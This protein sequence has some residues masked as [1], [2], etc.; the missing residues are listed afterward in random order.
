MTTVVEMVRKALEARLLA[1][2]P[3]L[4]AS[5]LDL[6]GERVPPIGPGPAWRAGE[7]LPLGGARVCAALACS[8]RAWRS[9]AAAAAP[10]VRTL[11]LARLPAGV[12]APRRWARPAGRGRG[13]NEGRGAPT[14]RE[15]AALLRR[16]GGVASLR[17]G[18]G[19]YRALTDGAVASIASSLPALRELRC[20]GG[21]FTESAAHA[22]TKRRGLGSKTARAL[23]KLCPRL[24][25]VELPSSYDLPTEGLVS[26]IVG[27]KALRVLDVGACWGYPH[28]GDL[29]PLEF[30]DLDELLLPPPGAAAEAR[31]ISEL[32][33]AERDLTPRGVCSV[34]KWAAPNLSVLDLSCS[35]LGETGAAAVGRLNG[36]EKLSLTRTT[37]AELRL[38]FAE[39]KPSLIHLTMSNTGTWFKAG[40]GMA[41]MHDEPTLV[42]I[43]CLTRANAPALLVLDMPWSDGISDEGLATMLGELGRGAG[44]SLDCIDLEGASQA[45]VETAE[46]LL[47]GACDGLVDLNLSRCVAMDEVLGARIA[48]RLHKNGLDR[49]MLGARIIQIGRGVLPFFFCNLDAKGDPKLAGVEDEIVGKVFDEEHLS[50]AFYDELKACPYRFY[51]L[52]SD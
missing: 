8:G 50:D 15:T 10:Y 44:G 6:C 26:L 19:V 36:L 45:A 40:M 42:D 16:F 29:P 23:V 48:G 28:D 14:H 20:G 24:E 7:A 2:P 27:L 17:C 25:I 18:R 46:V 21:N 35:E 30:G 52:E 11:T 12:P 43:S 31:G 39:P 13:R 9:A 47:S 34:L 1:L 3:P 38:I 41:K 49:M 5:V 4:L 33:L 32:C 51:D 22:T 37:S